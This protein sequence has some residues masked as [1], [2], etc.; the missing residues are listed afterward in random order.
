M[1]KRKALLPNCV[2]C[3]HKRHTLIANC[4]LS[5]IEELNAIKSH[6]FLK[7]GEA[8]FNEGE[9]PL[10]LYVLYQGELKLTVFSG[11]GKEQILRIILP[12]E[13]VGYR[14]L[15][16][17]TR[18]RASAIALMPSQVCIIPKDF[19]K[20]TLLKNP[21]VAMAMMQKLSS[22][23][24]RMQERLNQL[25]QKSV[26][27]R[28]A[29]AL[30]ILHQYNK[31]KYGKDYIDISMKDLASFIGSARETTSRTLSEFKAENLIRTEGRKIY[32]V[33]PQKLEFI[34]HLYD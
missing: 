3:P 23:L 6:R 7:K 32:I 19:F 25:V 29:E 20:Q 14:S 22:D 28:L 10:A 5:V 9:Q 16:A 21:K 26:V 17:E 13:I 15:I 30:L 2:E 33:N 34:A 24:G 11:Q 27:E 12:G 1:P 8:L 4:P 18:Y 31:E